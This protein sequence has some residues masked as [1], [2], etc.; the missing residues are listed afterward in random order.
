MMDCDTTGIEPDFSLS[1]FK[2]LVGGGSMVI[3]N[4]T[5]PRALK[6]LGY[7]EEQT[8]D[9]VAHLHET[10][11]VIIGAPHLKKEHYDVFATAVGENAI[12]YNGHIRMM[13]AV[14]PFLSGAI[15]KTVNMPESVTVEEVEQLHYDSWKLG[16]KS[17]A[18]YR[19][20]SKV[21]QPLS[22]K[23]DGKR[24]NKKAGEAVAS[25]PQVTRA[26][27]R[28]E[29]P[30]KRNS[31]TFS[32]FVS[33]LHGHFTVGEYE[34]G[35]PGELFIQVAKMGSTL[36]GVME[37]FGRSVS[38]G[39]QYGV[40]LRA[41]VKG[42][43]NTSFAPFGAT[44]DPEIR[45]ASSI[46]DYVFRR[47]ALEYLSI[48]DRLELGLATMEDLEAEMKAQQTSLI[49]EIPSETA[50][51]VVNELVAS[52]VTPTQERASEQAKRPAPKQDNSS[53]PLCS[54]CGNITQRAG[55][56]YVCTSCGSTTGCS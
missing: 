1:K 9:I 30:R 41:F 15:S 48:D 40:P 49:D 53:A 26:A 34:N 29:L 31:K 39:L 3:V 35:D 8:K 32:F 22:D 5:V 14:Q 25:E 13:G 47:L 19:D 56:W 23:K 54:S 42:L 36:A 11:G 46:M 38:Y 10:H 2:T 52:S 43:T 6:T 12:H 7:N 45:T 20:N 33:D 50:S 28:N 18:I 24:E 16:I 21:G 37:A 44:D 17:V 51:S 4:Q 55:S 27:M